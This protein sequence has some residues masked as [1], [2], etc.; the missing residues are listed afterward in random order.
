MS[1]PKGTEAKLR[2]NWMPIGLA[3]GAVL[4]LVVFNFTTTFGTL[5]NYRHYVNSELN[6][7]VTR[8]NLFLVFMS[9]EQFD[10]AGTI[11][12]SA[13]DWWKQKIIQ[14]QNMNIVT[15]T[16][17]P[18]YGTVGGSETSS[19]SIENSE[20]FVGVLKSYRVCLWMSGHVHQNHKSHSSIVTKWGTT[21]IDS[22]S[23]QRT[24]PAEKSAS[25]LL[26]FKVGSG[27]VVV[28]SR[29]HT[30]RIWNSNLDYSFNLTYDFRMENTLKDTFAIW[31]FSD[32]QPRN[33]GEWGDFENVIEDSN[34]NIS[35]EI[36]LV[37]GDLV[38]RDSTINYERYLT[39][40]SR[41]NHPREELYHLAGN[42]ESMPP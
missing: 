11:G 21:F 29:D 42:H 16:H 26:E 13:F 17:Q 40:L 23:I 35:Y 15:L 5:R 37:L 39:C 2:K 4:L 9:D 10:A 25:R 34:R 6:Y 28:R 31:V 41:I 3:I 36:A 18:L 1:F 7:T 8:G 24:N 33:E 38:A 27:K 30:N 12:D 32:I 20:R 22:G 19:G 14:N